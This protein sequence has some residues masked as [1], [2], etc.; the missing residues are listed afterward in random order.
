VINTFNRCESLAT[1][2]DSLRRQNYP[3]F[4]VVVVNGPSTDGTTALLYSRRDDLRVGTCAERNL[5]VSRNVGIA[6]AAG[7]L[8]AFIDDDGVP[9]ENWLADAVGS[10]DQDD[11]AG[12]G[13]FVYDHTGYRLQYRYSFAGRWTRSSAIREP[14]SI[15]ICKARTRSFAEVP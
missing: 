9:D 7:D 1:T 14:P 11:V 6:M 8:V 4:E 12:A 13:G 5:S 3:H 10:F 2:L 15:R